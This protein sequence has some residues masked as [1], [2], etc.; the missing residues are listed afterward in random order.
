MIASSVF[1][2]AVF[3]RRLA[4]LCCAVIA[5]CATPSEPPAP[6]SKRPQAREGVPIEPLP[7]APGAHAPVEEAAPSPGVI[8]QPVPL[9]RPAP[10]RLSAVEG[11]MRVSRLLPPGVAD[12]AGWAT[13]IHAAFSALD[14]A[15][16]ADN[17]C[18]AIAITEQESGFRADPRVPGLSRLAWQE[19]EKQRSRTGIPK[20]VLWGALALPSP[21]GKS[22]SARLDA[23]KTE[24][25]LSEIFE[26]FIG[27][28]PLAKP[29]L[30]NRNPVRTGGPMQVSVAYAQ[31]H[32]SARPYPYT[33]PTSV[34]HEVFKR[35]GG[36]YFGIAHL[37]DYAASYDAPIY[38]FADFNA[39]HY[40]SRNAAF[41]HAVTQASGV[42]LALDGD[43][44]RYEDGRPVKAAGSTE[45][46]V[47]VL[48]KRLRMSHDEIRRDLERSRAADF[49]RSRLYFRLF[50][51]AD[52]LARQPLPRA[53]LPRIRLQGPKIT[54]KLTTD[55]F[56]RR[57]DGRY[58]RCLARAAT[59]PY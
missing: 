53:M 47:R 52:G 7:P 6:A 17:F 36:L 50:V 54:R 32:A 44:L 38:R 33:V 19:I 1:L 18:A 9:P 23:V 10:P 55:W 15:Q 24:R 3:R 5:G 57:V 14:L 16:T 30:A 8:V 29:F 41:Q 27:M 42:P 20:V 31:A 48:A 26:D 56:A 40:A 4:A 45:R 49:E 2:S 59:L 25:E 43:L 58:R 12:R 39:G 46:A 11:R 22:Y 28:V 35:R 21:T 51:L 13:D 34:R 37:L